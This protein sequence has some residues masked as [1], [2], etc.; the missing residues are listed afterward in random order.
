MIWLPYGEKNHDDMLSRFHRIP[1]RY[2]RTDGQ[3]DR[4][5]ISI[6]RISILRCW[7]AIKCC[8]E[9]FA[10]FVYFLTWCSYSG[11]IASLFVLLCL[12]F[13][14]CVTMC[15]FVFLMIFLLPSGVINDDDDNIQKV[16]QRSMY[17]HGSLI[18]AWTIYLPLKITN[19]SFLYGSSN[20][21]INFL[22]HSV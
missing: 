9:S 12:M 10:S 11:F 20:S 22:I 14:L 8:M 19:R 7:R 16:S 13:D 2:G 15:I 18:Q 4:F 17:P 6:S 5:A 21:R 3:T 1:E